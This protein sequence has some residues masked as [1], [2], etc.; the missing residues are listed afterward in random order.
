MKKKRVW[1]KALNKKVELLKNKI[2][3]R[4]GKSVILGILAIIVKTRHI[5]NRILY[6]GYG[7]ESMLNDP[8]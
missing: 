5:D 4:L 3:T 7:D 8:L 6:E 2:Y 1:V